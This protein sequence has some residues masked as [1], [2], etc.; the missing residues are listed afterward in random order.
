MTLNN[1]T[2]TGPTW[3]QKCLSMSTRHRIIFDDRGWCNACV[4]AETK[5]TLDWT[6]RAQE[7]ELL[8]D[9]HRR[10]DGGIECLIPVSGGKDGS[11]VAH[12][13]KHTY[14]I[15]VIT[16]TIAPPLPLELG[17]ENLAAFQASGYNH[18]TLNPN[19][20]GMMKLNKVG[21]I[22]MGMPY[23][24]WNTSILAA[25]VRL[26]SQLDIS[27]VFYTENGD[28]EYGG[29]Q[30]LAVNPIY[31]QNYMKRIYLEQGYDRMMD[32]AN[33]SPEEAYFFQF[34]DEVTTRKSRT[35]FV[36]WS[37]FE[38]WD[39]YRN[40]LVAKEHCGLTE[41]TNSNV[42]TFTNFSQNDQA[43]YHLHCYLMYLKFGFGRANQDA[44]IEI[45]RGAMTRDQGINLVRLYDGQYPEDFVELYCDYFEMTKNE[46]TA[47][48]DRWVNKALFKKEAKLWRPQFIIK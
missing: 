5:Q 3:C 28:V 35:K 29:Q 24:G 34:P 40:Y 17:Q 48:F 45:R 46:L 4:W 25:I 43:L 11:Y 13:L 18:I 21:L 27:L 39:P 16:V 6:A 10:T 15:H 7:L 41:N 33:L 30:E 38:S 22:E 37:Y 8:L 2:M 19:P 1:E 47:V 9:T 20:R 14:G 44:C 36:H 32:M 12:N 23:Y 26:S 31:D 42:G